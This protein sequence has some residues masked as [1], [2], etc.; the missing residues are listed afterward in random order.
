M[1]YLTNDYIVAR[2]AVVGERTGHSTSLDAN[3]PRTLADVP[4]SPTNKQTMSTQAAVPAPVYESWRA[5]DPD[6]FARRL[7]RA[8]ETFVTRYNIGATEARAE[9]QRVFLAVQLYLVMQCR[10]Q[11]TIGIETRGLVM[12]ADTRPYYELMKSATYGEILLV[13]TAIYLMLTRTIEAHGSA[14]VIVGVVPSNERLEQA[15]PSTG[16]LFTA[17][18]NADGTGCDPT[19]G[20]SEFLAPAAAIRTKRERLTPD[21]AEPAK[22][23]RTK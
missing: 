2:I 11:A 8:L 18:R 13:V 3:T 17:K 9:F 14:A 10:N 16:I 19:P 7:A 1:D 15:S 5:R 23:P 21:A 20:L 4:R 12:L 22:L 6:G